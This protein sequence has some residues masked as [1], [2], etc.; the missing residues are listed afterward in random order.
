MMLIDIYNR[1]GM[2]AIG[3]VDLVQRIHR[4]QPIPAL[5]R[6][7][8]QILQAV[9]VR[10]TEEQRLQLLQEYSVEMTQVDYRDGEYLLERKP[11]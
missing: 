4:N 5:G 1:F 11:K 2:K 7:A 6:M 8:F 10:L 9:L 3:Q